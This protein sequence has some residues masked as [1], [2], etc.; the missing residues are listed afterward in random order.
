MRR[1]ASVLLV[2]AAGCDGTMVFPGLLVTR[3]EQ[4]PQG[5]A[6]APAEHAPPVANTSGT[7]LE[8]RRRYQVVAGLDGSTTVQELSP[9]LFDTVR[10]EECSWATAEDGV[11]RCLPEAFTFV[12]TKVDWLA[13]QL[14]AGRPP[15]L[16]A[17]S[18]DIDNG[19]DMVLIPKGGT[20]TTYFMLLESV[21]LYD[22]GIP[23]TNMSQYAPKWRFFAAV[24]ACGAW[25]QD[26]NDD[27]YDGFML[28]PV[29]PQVFQAGN[30]PAIVT[31]PAE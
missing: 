25:N 3:G 26:V 1:I 7:R 29:D 14:A 12:G 2:A 16:G 19:V 18:S 20:A 30:P 21:A 27:T 11:T 13:E 9:I 4:G 28:H 22:K 31:V 24:G 6:G 23:A 15:I 17:C 8:V 10:Q 5:P